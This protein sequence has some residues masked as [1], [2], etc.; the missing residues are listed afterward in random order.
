MLGLGVTNSWYGGPQS[1]HH[2][3]HVSNMVCKIANDRVD[4]AC[5]VG[6]NM[7]MA[8]AFYCCLAVKIK[9]SSKCSSIFV[10]S[11]VRVGT[12]FL[13]AFLIHFSRPKLSG[14]T[15]YQA[16]YSMDHLFSPHFVPKFSIWKYKK[17]MFRR[18]LLVGASYCTVP[19]VEPFFIGP[20][21]QINT[22]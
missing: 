3:M 18:A 21:I 5:F 10:L 14:K 15:I 16:R 20:S 1:E 19:S 11:F 13:H 12:L 2:Y 17:A 4:V 9:G 22:A 6:R 8:S 7:L